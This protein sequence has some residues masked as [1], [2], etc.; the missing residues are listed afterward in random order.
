MIVRAYALERLGA[1]G[2]LEAARDKVSASYILS[3]IE[4][5]RTIAYEVQTEALNRLV[6]EHDN[7]RVVLDWVLERRDV[8]FWLRMSWGLRQFWELRG[9]AVEGADWLERLLARAE[10]P[11]TTD[12]I[13][14]QAEAW[15]ILM[16][17][18]HRLSRFQRA[19][20]AG[21]HALALARAQG[22]AI[23]ISNALNN[24]ANP[25]TALGDFDRAEPLYLE[26]LAI[27][28]AE[29][30]RA[31]E[32]TSLL[33]LGELRTAQGRYDEALVFHDEALVISESLS[34][35]EA[36]RALI[37]SNKG[38]TLIMMDR[39]AEAR[40][41]LIE[42]QRFYDL[43]NQ[44]ISLGLNALGRACWRLGAYA[45][46]LGYLERSMRQSR[47]QDDVASLAHAL[48][49]AA[50]IALA[51]GDL[52]LAWQV[53]S[54]ANILVSRVSD[55][56]IQWRVVERGAAIAC[57]QGAF[58]AAVRLYAA[59]ARGR[60]A[61]HDLV[62]PAERDLRALDHATALDALGEQVL[63]EAA[64]GGQALSFD[65]A[66][67]LARVAIAAPPVGDH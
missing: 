36:S 37:L 55:R 8:A 14:A 67:E 16:I 46:A 28:H 24:L 51:Q 40:T 23:A 49:T 19:A 5:V 54:E 10:P 6:P 9:F 64:R 45:E 33:N 50:G 65:E 13:K 7:I 39:S 61:L 48:C 21:E 3:L 43:Y 66:A 31:A 11:R 18:D 34:E 58:D 20:E 17:M 53:I 29:G 30:N 32:E 42:S 12:E 1:E 59:A 56:R 27:Y 26:S 15:K 44:P 22:D 62:D 47:R 4:Q 41:V 63:A 38:E 60:D 25:I 35:Q 57:R 2:E 52:T